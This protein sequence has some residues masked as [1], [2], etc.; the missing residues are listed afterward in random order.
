MNKKYFEHSH[1]KMIVEGLHFYAEGHEYFYNGV[2]LSGVTGKIGKRLKKNFDTHA[3]EEGRSQGSHVHGAI[4]DFIRTGKRTSVHP[5]VLWAI[6]ELEGFIE[7][8]HRLYSEV[9]VSDFK[10]YASAIDIVDFVGEKDVF[11]FDTKAGNFSRDYVSWQ[12]GVYKYFLESTTDFRVKKC[13]CMSTKDH[14]FYPI[15]P[16]DEEDVQGL[17][18]G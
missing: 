8:G 11:I 15:I 18:Y 16:R 13:F 4:E 7:Q 6:N 3:V 17:L 9:L 2:Q 14:D 10:K 1:G 5:D 12:L